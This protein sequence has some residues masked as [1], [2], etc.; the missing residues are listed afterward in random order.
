MR[1][2]LPLV[3]TY[4]EL[5]EI[6]VETRARPAECNAHHDSGDTSCFTFLDVQKGLEHIPDLGLSRWSVKYAIDKPR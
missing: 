5:V 2:D 4:S 1:S 3:T 6:S